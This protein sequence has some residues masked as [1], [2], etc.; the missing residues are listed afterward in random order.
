MM[1][2]GSGWQDND[3]GSRGSVLRSHVCRAEFVSFVVQLFESNFNVMSILV[4]QRCPLTFKGGTTPRATR[5][6][7]RAFALQVRELTAVTADEQHMATTAKTRG[8]K[9][10]KTLIT[11]KLR[12]IK[13]FSPKGP[14]GRQSESVKG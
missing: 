12:K 10:K 7:S 3:R 14:R 13:S 11:F 6:A 2:D 9:K 4:T 5:R 8:F 1:R